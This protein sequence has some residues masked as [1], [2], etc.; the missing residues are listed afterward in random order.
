[1]RHIINAMNKQDALNI[2]DDMIDQLPE[3]RSGFVEMWLSDDIYES[4]NMIEYKGFKLYTHK[5]M[6]ED[7]ALI[8]EGSVFHK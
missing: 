6:P 8:Q 4:L 1:M 3:D 7:Y 5:M 2:L